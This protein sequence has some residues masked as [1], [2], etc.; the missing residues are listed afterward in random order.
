VALLLSQ[1]KRT[2]PRSFVDLEGND[3]Q[4]NDP[5]H[6]AAQHTF[7]RNSHVMPDQHVTPPSSFTQQPL[8]PPP[9]D[10]K[11]FAQARRVIALFRDRKAGSYTKEEPWKEFRLAPEEYAEVERLLSR[12]EALWGYVD[13]KIRYVI[14]PSTNYTQ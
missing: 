1:P 9:T 2:G 4:S 13:D 10:E 5:L 6:D 12:D 11:P 7:I 14:T 8:T 3:L